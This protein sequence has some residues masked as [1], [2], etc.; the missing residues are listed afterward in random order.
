VTTAVIAPALADALAPETLDTIEHALTGSPLCTVCDSS[1]SPGL[2]ENP[3]VIALLR[4]DGTAMIRFAHEL[5]APPRVIAVERPAPPPPAQRTHPTPKVTAQDGLTWM[6]S[7]RDGMLPTVALVCDVNQF[8]ALEISGETL[9]NTLRVEGLRG[10]RPI[11]QL[12][13]AA[14][15]RLSLEREDAILHLVTLWGAEPLALTDATATIA[16]LHLAARQH[17]ML[18]ILGCD[19]ALTTGTLEE[20]ERQLCFADA[21]ATEVT[22]SDTELANVPLRP[23]PRRRAAQVALALTPSAR[24]RRRY[25][26]EQR[27][28]R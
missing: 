28:S 9:L 18:L 15:D 4:P 5:C 24:A 8:A 26:R 13:P 2:E 20:T 19:L 12:R 6:L 14:T 22:Y 16:L 17:A 21:I 23:G 27:R 3:S 11:D 10:G 25:N 7:V 1:I